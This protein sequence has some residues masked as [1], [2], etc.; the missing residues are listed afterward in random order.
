LLRKKIEHYEIASYGSLCELCDVLGYSK[1]SD[2]LGRSLDEE[3]TT[4]EELTELAQDINDEA[5]EMSNERES[6]LQA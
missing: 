6:M 5:H 4:D 3:E 2:L 1:L